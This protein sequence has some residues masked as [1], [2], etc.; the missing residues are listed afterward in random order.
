MQRPSDAIAAIESKDPPPHSATS[1]SSKTTGTGV[2][3]EV[4]EEGI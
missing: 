3:V 1:I 4:E 2:V